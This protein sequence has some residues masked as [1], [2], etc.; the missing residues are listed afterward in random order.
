EEV[1]FANGEIKSVINDSVRGKD[2]YVVQLIDDPHSNKSVN[3]NIMSLLTAINAAYNSDAARITAVIPQFPYSRQERK[4]GREAISAKIVCNAIEGAGANRVITLDIHSEAIEGFFNK[5]KLENLHAGRAVISYVMDNIQIK[6]LMVVA[7]DVGSAGRGKYFAHRM[8]VDL[9]IIDKTR[10]YVQS[11]EISGMR[12]VGS[13]KDKDVFIPDDMIATGG[14]L[15]SALKLIKENGARDIHIA[16]SLPFFNGDAV[17]KFDKA[18]KE[19]LFKCVFGTD[20]VFWGDKF[21]KEHPWYKEITIAELFGNVIYS[22]NQRRS[23][24]SLML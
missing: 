16:V 23:V 22:L 4:K 7:P 12:L 5:A 10:D 18:Y 1:T 19:G 24:S 11:S 15:L 21:Q 6:D 14:T 9:A 2:V 8:G 13:V 3:D 20:A 17:D